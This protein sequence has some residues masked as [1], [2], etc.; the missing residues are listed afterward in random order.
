VAQLREGDLYPLRVSGR[1]AGE[2]LMTRD[3]VMVETRTN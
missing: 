1:M 3:K 2:P